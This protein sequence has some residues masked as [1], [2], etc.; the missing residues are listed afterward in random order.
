MDIQDELQNTIMMADAS[1]KTLKSTSRQFVE[2]EKEY[3]TLLRLECLKLKEEGMAIG[4][5]DKTCYGLDNVAAARA[6]AHLAEMTYEA[7]KEAMQWYKLKARLL[8][9]QIQ[10]E[11][12]NPEGL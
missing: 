7:N 8:D 4:M 5:I 12:N 6:K 2:A 9:N 11:W 3:K 1:L 10:R